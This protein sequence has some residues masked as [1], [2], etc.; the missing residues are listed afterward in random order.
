M[1]NSWLLL[2]L[3]AQRTTKGIKKKTL[4][5]KTPAA[6]SLPSWN[7]YAIAC[8]NSQRQPSLLGNRLFIDICTLMWPALVRKK[9]TNI[10]A[11]TS[12]VDLPSD[13]C[14]TLLWPRACGVKWKKKG[15]RNKWC[16]TLWPVSWFKMAAN[17]IASCHTFGPLF[18]ASKV[19]TVGTAR[20]NG[21]TRSPYGKLLCFSLRMQL[22]H[23][24]LA[25]SVLMVWNIFYL[26]C[27]L[28]CAGFM[29]SSVFLRTGSLAG[30]YVSVEL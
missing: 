1:N 22:S 18:E 13:L 17:I 9:Q 21:Y 26:L 16:K 19:P 12:T 4:S 14:F 8:A 7:H 2:S 23:V 29:A 24:I 5:G 27:L 20:L 15:C 25:D 11:T 28:P 30:V 6:V 3:I 10:L